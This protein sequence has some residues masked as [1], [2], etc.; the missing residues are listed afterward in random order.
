MEKPK[1]ILIVDD[2]QFNNNRV[3][4]LLK[5]HGFK[6]IYEISSA[7]EALDL[8]KKEQL[9]IV[10]ID[11]DLKEKGRDGI[12]LAKQINIEQSVPFIFLTS[13]LAK[14]IRKKAIETLPF[15][16]LIK[17]FNPNELL[18]NI[19]LALHKFSQSKNRKEKLSGFNLLKDGEND[20]LKI[21]SDEILYLESIGNHVLIHTKNVAYPLNTS[22]KDLLLNLPDSKFIQTHEGYIVNSSEISKFND[23]HVIIHNSEIPVSEE[24]LDQLDDL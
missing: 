5:L 1:N 10:I 16:Y 21:S 19:D 6:K 23:S 20:I 24:Y 14:D 4:S 22:V 9:D 18:A 15:A 3:I 12:W 8:I 13:N 2:Q 7:Q 11:I 17:P